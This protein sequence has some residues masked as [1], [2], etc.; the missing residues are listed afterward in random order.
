[1]HLYIYWEV[2]K[3]GDG[4]II[5]QLRKTQRQTEKQE[6]IETRE[7]EADIRER[8]KERETERE[9][10]KLIVK[11]DRGTDDRHGYRLT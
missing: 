6:H 8:E 5:L 3:I 4:Y 2:I 11:S 7:T 10:M 1:M 9:R